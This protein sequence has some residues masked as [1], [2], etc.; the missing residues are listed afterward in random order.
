MILPFFFFI[1]LILFFFFKKPSWAD[2]FVLLTL[3]IVNGLVGW[4]EHKKAGD[5]VDALKG[6]LS[7]LANVKRNNAWVQIAGRE[8]VPGDKVA[9]SIGGAVPADCRVIGPKPIYCDQASL[10]GESLPVKIDL[11]KRAKKKKEERNAKEERTRKRR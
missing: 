3:Q 4:Y 10:T 9:L 11:G 5:A 1:F 8:L 6:S 7:P 2:F